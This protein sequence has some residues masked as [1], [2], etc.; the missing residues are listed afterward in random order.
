MTQQRIPYIIQ[1]SAAATSIT[2]KDLDFRFA[3]YQIRTI[4]GSCTGSDSILV[5]VSPVPIGDHAKVSFLGDPNTSIG[6]HTDFFVT[7]SS[8]T[9]VFEDIINGPW[10]RVKVTKTGTSGAATVYLLG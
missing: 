3:P 7:V 2:T 5:Q 10:C 9:G 4:S 6:A 8:Y 1:L